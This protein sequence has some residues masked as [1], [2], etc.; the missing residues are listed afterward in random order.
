MFNYVKDL[1]RFLDVADL[2]LLRDDQVDV[3]V[4][5]DEVPVGAALHGAFDPHEAVF[6]CSLENSL[7]I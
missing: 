2:G 5:V 3:H 1:H 6:L 4:G 7:G